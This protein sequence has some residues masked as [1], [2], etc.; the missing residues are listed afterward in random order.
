MS[1]SFLY[2]GVDFG[3]TYG[4]YLKKGVNIPT[5]VGYDIK[6]KSLVGR[7][8]E[9]NF[10]ATATSRAFTLPCTINK[11]GATS[12]EERALLI[13]RDLSPISGEKALIFNSMPDK[14]LMAMISRGLDIPRLS[15]GDFSISFKASSPWWYSLEQT[16]SEKAVIAGLEL[17]SESVGGTADSDPEWILDVDTP[18]PNATSI[19]IYNWTDGNI[20]KWLAPRNLIVGDQ[21]V[22]SAIDWSIRLNGLIS[23]ATKVAGGIPPTLVG[24]YTNYIQVTGM[25]GCRLTIKYYERWQ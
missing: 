14:M 24:G 18:I 16:E 13:A 23:I 19:E 12:L 4:V 8:G 22:F 21:I 6:T 2:G 1:N 17:I 10:G 5:L 20:L 15:W 3:A 25:A 9:Y 11:V 7:H